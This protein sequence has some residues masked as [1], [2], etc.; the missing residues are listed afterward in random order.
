MFGGFN[1]TQFV[2]EMYHYPIV[3][4]K[5]DQWWALEFKALHY[6]DEMLKSYDVLPKK[7]NISD[8]GNT[9]FAVVDT[10][11]SMMSVPQGIFEK[12]V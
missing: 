7:Q 1:K 9:S 3:S 11:S 2:G 4:D 5:S 10:G 12:L 8:M 6:D